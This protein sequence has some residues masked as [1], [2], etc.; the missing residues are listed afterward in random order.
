MRISYPPQI[1]VTPNEPGYLH[2]AGAIVE[3]L[4]FQLW[5]TSVGLRLKEIKTYLYQSLGPDSPCKVKHD[6]ITRFVRL[7]WIYV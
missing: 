1:P 3:V 2:D 6:L 7:V 4:Y 5:W